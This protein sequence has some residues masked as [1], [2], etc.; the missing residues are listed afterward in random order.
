MGDIMTRETPEVGWWCWCL[1]G[2]GAH[3]HVYNPDGTYEIR[4]PSWDVK[5]QE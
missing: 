3:Y 2:K 5:E 4:Y 1:K